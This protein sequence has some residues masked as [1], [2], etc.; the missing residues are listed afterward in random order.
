MRCAIHYAVLL[1]ILLLTGVFVIVPCI[2]L[3]MLPVRLRLFMPQQFEI[4]PLSCAMDCDI[5]YVLY[6]ATNLVTT[7]AIELF[8]WYHALAFVTG[9]RNSN[10]SEV[11]LPNN[12]GRSALR[13]LYGALA[14]KTYCNAT[15]DLLWLTTLNACS[16]PT[17]FLVLVDIRSCYR[18]SLS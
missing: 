16:W 10:R 1:S 13:P 4:V 9:S 15:W 17:I 3:I 5:L 6:S 18:T 2:I 14:P 8:M 12:E 7:C 11:E